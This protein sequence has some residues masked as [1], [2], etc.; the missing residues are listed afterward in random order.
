MDDSVIRPG[1]T[2]GIFGG[3]QLGRMLALA[4]RRLGYRFRVFDPSPQSCAA[5]VCEE[6]MQADY[7]D[8]EAL[9]RFANGCDVITVEFENV[10]ASALELAGTYAP[11]RPSAHALTV[12][13][14]RLREKTFLRENGFPCAPFA[15]VNSEEEL[16]VALE[17]FGRPAILKSAAFGYD[18]K[19]QVRVDDNTAVSLAWRDLGVPQGV[20]EGRID[21]AGEYSVIVARNSRGETSAF[22]LARNE[23]RHGILD[24]STVPAAF[25]DDLGDP[26]PLCNAARSLA[27]EIT[28]T[29][30]VEGLLAVELFLTS[31]GAWLVNELAPRPHNS[32]H[33]TFDACVTSQFEQHVRAITNLPLG[34]TELLRP[35]KMTNLLGDRWFP[36]GPDQPAV[37]PDWARCLNEPNTKLHLYDKGAPKPGRKMGH[38]TEFL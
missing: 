9:R 1:A 11:T 36:H 17:K 10:P 13:Q 25:P 23:H 20:L 6:F 5:A 2:I 8:E 33:W 27:V 19:G 37:D 35:A 29:L 24:T 21:F 34:H 30:G 15:E 26:A 16:D 28:R 12:C 22:P 32:G 7:D 3:G 31:S 38:L 14:H 4:G 18:G